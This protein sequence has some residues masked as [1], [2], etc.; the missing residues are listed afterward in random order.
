MKSNEFEKIKNLLELGYKHK[1]IVSELG[2]SINQVK[3]ISRLNNIYMKLEEGGLE[4]DL[5]AVLKNLKYKALLLHKI[6]DDIDSLR[7]LLLSIKDK[8]NIT[9]REINERVN[10]I[11][12]VDDLTKKEINANRKSAIMDKLINHNVVKITALSHLNNKN[13]ICIT[14]FCMNDC[15]FDIISYND[16]GI[17]GFNIILDNDKLKNTLKEFASKIEYK[18]TNIINM[19]NEFYIITLEDNENDNKDIVEIYSSL[20]GF[21]YVK[22]D[23]IENEYKISKIVKENIRQELRDSV[24]ISIKFKVSR[25]LTES[26][27]LIQLNKLNKLNQYF[28]K[29]KTLK[30][31]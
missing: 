11:I 1:D 29:A 20:I 28:R 2:V 18:F 26:N 25:D 13:H 10:L 24:S 9:S 8:E 14:D 22:Y 31:E 21:I 6:F 17:Y 5:L 27:A 19:C 7:E 12:S 23:E 3:K 30:Y 4:S 16:E 15:M